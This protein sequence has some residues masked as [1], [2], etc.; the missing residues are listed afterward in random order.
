MVGNIQNGLSIREMWL[1]TIQ[2]TNT[3]VDHLYLKQKAF[4][5][6]ISS[7][8][9]ESLKMS[10]QEMGGEPVWMGTESSAYYGLNKTRGITLF[11]NDKNGYNYYHYSKVLLKG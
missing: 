7:V 5:I 1:A 3:L 11:V 10:I 2:R 9:T 6:R 8:L 4:F